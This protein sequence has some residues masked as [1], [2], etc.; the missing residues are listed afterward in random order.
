MARL[1]REIDAISC[2]NAPLRKASYKD[3][4]THADMDRR[5]IIAHSTQ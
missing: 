3:S 2:K 4:L 5:I 1:A